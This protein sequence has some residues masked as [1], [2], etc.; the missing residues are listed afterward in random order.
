MRVLCVCRRGHTRS[1][2]MATALA[3]RGHEA[4]AVG[5]EVAPSSLSVLEFWAELVLVLDEHAW[6][7]LHGSNSKD[8]EFE[9]VYGNPDHP[10]LIKLC[11]D[12][13]DQEGL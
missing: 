5:W 6:E 1:V 2:A 7:H 11:R 4:V 3:G 10:D 12:L 8:M 9:D 13:L